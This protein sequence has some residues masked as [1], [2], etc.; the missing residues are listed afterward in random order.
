MMKPF[1]W[2]RILVPTDL[3]P[4][5][6]RAVRYAHRLA[7]GVGAEL[8]VFHVARDISELVKN[9]PTTGVVDKAEDDDYHLWLRGLLG[10]SGSVRRVEAVR[11]R[12]DVAEAIIEYATN[13][14]INL[15]VIATHGRTGLT[16][17]LMGSVTEKVLR[18]A[19]C[20]VLVLPRQDMVPIA[21]N[22]PAEPVPAPA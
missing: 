12:A 17:L 10:E 22:L 3:S 7:E 2:E 21:A 19:H 8:H 13:N 16:H 20:P 4:F 15:I 1:G 6:E 11:V 18:L 5:A 9:L 14:N